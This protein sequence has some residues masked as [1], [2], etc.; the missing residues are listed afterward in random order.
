M[1]LLLV[2]VLAYTFVRELFFLSTTHKLINKLMSRNYHE[3]KLAEEL[4]LSGKKPE[5]VVLQEPGERE[6]FE[7][8]LF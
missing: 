1:T 3:Y 7:S 2:F 5:D 8:M 6:Q 4:E